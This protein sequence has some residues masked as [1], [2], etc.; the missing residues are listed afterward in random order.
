MGVPVRSGQPRGS[1][2]TVPSVSLSAPQ[3]PSRQNPTSYLRAILAGDGVAVFWVLDERHIHTNQGSAVGSHYLASD[4]RNQAEGER[5]TSLSH[6][7]ENK[8][9]GG[10]VST[11]S[12]PPPPT[13]LQSSSGPQGKDKTFN[14]NFWLT[15]SHLTERRGQEDVSTLPFS[16]QQN[17]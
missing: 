11:P 5:N 2:P 8:E 14:S 1:R 6:T 7:Q 17:R 10:R 3:V 15:R 13:P 16:D 12:P 9:T 4:E